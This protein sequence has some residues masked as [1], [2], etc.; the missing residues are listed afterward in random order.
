[1]NSEGNERMTLWRY[2]RPSAL[3]SRKGKMPGAT[4]T[5]F[6]APGRE[7]R[8]SATRGNPLRAGIGFR[9]VLEEY[10]SIPDH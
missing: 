7:C 8:A 9:E 4:E 6:I 10:V 2:E 5:G 1:M 3:Q